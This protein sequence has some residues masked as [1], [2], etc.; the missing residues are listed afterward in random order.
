MI[1]DIRPEWKG[2]VNDAVTLLHYRHVADK[3]RLARGLL[4]ERAVWHALN[5]VAPSPGEWLS[6]ATSQPGNGN[7]P[8][9]KFGKVLID[10]KLV[11]DR[12]ETLVIKYGAQHLTHVY[13]HWVPRSGLKQLEILGALL[14]PVPET[15]GPAS[16][17]PSFHAL[18]NPSFDVR[19]WV[20]PR[21]RLQPL[22]TI[23]L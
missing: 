4:A 8:D 2:D 5:K 11:A 6:L 23:F 17:L 16:A 15:F 19:G 12:H 22:E 1:I 18:R 14:A 9:L 21:Q 13:T 7:A 3:R 20:I 10:V